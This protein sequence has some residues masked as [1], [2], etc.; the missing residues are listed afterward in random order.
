MIPA[1][2]LESHRKCLIC[3]LSLFRRVG[4]NFL[5]FDRP[6]ASVVLSC[7]RDT[8]EFLVVEHLG[9]QI[10]GPGASNGARSL[11]FEED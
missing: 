11:L 10:H 8:T 6:L 7:F 4:A 9:I 5:Q 3:H 1:Q 2:I